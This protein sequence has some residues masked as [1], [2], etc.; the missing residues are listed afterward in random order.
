MA[1]LHCVQC[2]EREGIKYI[3]SSLF[4]NKHMGKNVQHSYRFVL[5]IKLPNQLPI[6]SGINDLPAN[7][8]L[9]LGMCS[10]SF[11]PGQ[12]PTPNRANRVVRV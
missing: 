10:I 4:G 1:V 7:E 12:D 2:H 5:Q 6:I 9:Y 8:E 11:D 3:K